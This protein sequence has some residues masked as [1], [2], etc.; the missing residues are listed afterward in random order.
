MSEELLELCASLSKPEKAQR[1]MTNHPSPSSLCNYL[2]YLACS[3]APLALLKVAAAVIAGPTP[4]GVS[5][6]CNATITVKR[7]DNNSSV[8][9]HESS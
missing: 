6:T 4:A 2:L 3:P 8:M 9:V 1:H 5:V 7:V